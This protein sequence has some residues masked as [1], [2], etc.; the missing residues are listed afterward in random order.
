VILGRAIYF[1]APVGCHLRRYVFE[2]RASH[3]A[4][5]R[6]FAASH[7]R[8]LKYRVGV[9]LSKIEGVGT[10]GDK[11]WWSFRRTPS[12]TKRPF[13]PLEFSNLLIG[14]ARRQTPARFSP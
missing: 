11:G 14:V 6:I 12:G 13:S 2:V 1:C 8:A 3:A 7:V 4:V 9:W 10:Q 5:N